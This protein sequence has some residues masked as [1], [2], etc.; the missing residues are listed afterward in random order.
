MRRRGDQQ[1]RQQCESQYEHGNTDAYGNQHAG[2]EYELKFE[3]EL[4][5]EFEHE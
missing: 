3:R 1:H 4:E 5:F 2:V